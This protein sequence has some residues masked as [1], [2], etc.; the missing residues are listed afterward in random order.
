MLSDSFIYLT[1]TFITKSVVEMFQLQGCISEVGVGLCCRNGRICEVS[2][3]IPMLGEIVW[4]LVN[5]KGRPPHSETDM[6]LINKLERII[7]I[8]EN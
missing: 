4:W 5:E 1:F 8:Y 3:D 2:S 6:K 7:I